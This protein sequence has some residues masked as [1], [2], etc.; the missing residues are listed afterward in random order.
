MLA[1]GS[2]AVLKGFLALAE[3]EHLELGLEVAAARSALARAKAIVDAIVR[4][5]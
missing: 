4:T 1:H 5:D 2:D 3:R